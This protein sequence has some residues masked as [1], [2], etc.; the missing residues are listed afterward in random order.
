[1]KKNY[2]IGDVIELLKPYR[3]NEERESYLFT[4][5]QG[6]EILVQ[7]PET[8]DILR[9][10]GWGIDFDSR[11]NTLYVF[12]MDKYVVVAKCDDGD[13]VISRNDEIAFDID[14]TNEI[15]KD[16]QDMGVEIEI[17]RYDDYKE[18]TL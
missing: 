4:E 8:A 18:M 6:S 16:H 5:E 11:D 1:M 9:E 17:M 10:N 13:V 7:C 15:A 3:T 12:N 14:T 2:G